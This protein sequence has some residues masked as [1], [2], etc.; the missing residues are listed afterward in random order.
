MAH[1]CHQLCIM[2]VVQVEFDAREI[3]DADYHG[4][5]R[6]LQQ[7]NYKYVLFEFTCSGSIHTIFSFNRCF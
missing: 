3:E 5:R 4:I 2:Q 7:V 6:L 1:L